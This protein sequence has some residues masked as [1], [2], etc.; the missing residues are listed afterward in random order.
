MAIYML[1]CLNEFKVEKELKDTPIAR[2]YPEVFPDDV[3]SLPP[4]K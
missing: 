2:E 4:E 1:V 3:E